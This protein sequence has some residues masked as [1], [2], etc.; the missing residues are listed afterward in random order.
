MPSSSNWCFT[1][2]NYA[3]SMPDVDLE[4]DHRVVYYCFQEEIGEEGTPH[5]QGYVEFKRNLTMGEVSKL[6]PTAHLEVRRGTQEEAIAYCSK[7]DTRIPYTFTYIYGV[8]KRGKGKTKTKEDVQTLVWELRL[9]LRDIKR[10]HANLYARHSNAIKEL[11]RERDGEVDLSTKFDISTFNSQPLTDWTMSHVIWGPT[12][13]GKTSFARAHFTN[14]LFVTDIDQLSTFDPAI[15][16]GIVFDEMSFSQ[17]PPGA[18]INLV[19]TEQNREI[20]I[21][22]TTVRIPART[23][24]IF[25]YNEQDVFGLEDF[26]RKIPISDEQIK[27]IKRRVNFYQIKQKLY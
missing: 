2:N 15:H 12:G 8:P 4:A 21:R 7:E 22:Y 14:A 27:A 16:D 3:D 1:I 23:K 11:V 6:M 10:N 9:T 17:W 13:C 20:R 26:H 18:V 19:D 5:L 25:C 24:K